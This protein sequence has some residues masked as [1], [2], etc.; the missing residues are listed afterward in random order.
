MGKAIFKKRKYLREP[1]YKKFKALLTAGVDVSTLKKISGRVAR[2]INGVRD[3][4]N[5]TEYEERFHK[6]KVFAPRVRKTAVY[7]NGVVSKEK[8]LDSLI[9]VE[10]ELKSVR[11]MFEKIVGTTL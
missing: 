6:A 2:T 8:I 5:F 1:E 11:E 10:T 3:T 7:S 4:K 9:L